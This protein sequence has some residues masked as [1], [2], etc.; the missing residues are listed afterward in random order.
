MLFSPGVD[1][2]AILSIIL[3]HS[4]LM[5]TQ[6]LLK[7]SACFSNVKTLTIFA[8][9]FI[10]DTFLSLIFLGCFTCTRA[11]RR[12][13]F[14]LLTVFT[15]SGRHVLIISLIPGMQGTSRSLGDVW[16]V[17]VEILGVGRA[18]RFPFT[19]VSG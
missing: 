6:S 1:C 13:H 18:L 7:G 15:P 3:R 11:L 19:T 12:V 9:N 4:I 5:F 2:N 10:N 16:L 17:W 8:W 14:D